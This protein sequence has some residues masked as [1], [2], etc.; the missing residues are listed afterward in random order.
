MDISYPHHPTPTPFTP[1]LGPNAQCRLAL[2]SCLVQYGGA[3]FDAI[4]N[5]KAVSSLL[6]GIY[7]YEYLY[8]YMCI[9]EYLCM[10][11]CMCV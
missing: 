11:L 6:E 7:I 10:C 9:Y 3:N 2:A 8:I 1:L 4:T 5:T